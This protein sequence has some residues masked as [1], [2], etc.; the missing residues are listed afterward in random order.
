MDSTVRLME[1][2]RTESIARNA[3]WNYDRGLRKALFS[4]IMTPPIAIRTPVVL[5]RLG[6]PVAS[7]ISFG[8]QVLAK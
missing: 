7:E 3:R 2:P 6:L 8:V 4:G 5:P 1:K